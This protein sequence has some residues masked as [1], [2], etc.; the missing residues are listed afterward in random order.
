MEC[1]AKEDHNVKELFR[2]FLKLANFDHHGDESDEKSSIRRR[3]S[4]YVRNNKSQSKHGTTL[5]LLEVSSA[6][7]DG[8][9]CPSGSNGTKPDDHLHP[10]CSLPVSALSRNKPRSRSLIRRSSRKS[11]HQVGEAG[12]AECSDCKLT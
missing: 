8:A 11:K 3:S 10:P 1:S 6:D 5:D 9:I 7:K 4:T 2:A 12:S